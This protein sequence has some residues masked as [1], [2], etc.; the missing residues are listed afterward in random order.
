MPSLTVWQHIYANV[1]REQSPEHTAGFQTLYYSHEGLTREDIDTIESRVFYLFDAER[2]SKKAFFQTSSGK[3]VLSQITANADR[4]RAGRSGLYLAHSFILERSAF[5][6]AGLTPMDL[7]RQLPFAKTVDDA[8]K[9]GVSQAGDIKPS[10][11]DLSKP[12]QH[13][14]LKWSIDGRRLFARFVTQTARLQN[15]RSAVALVGIPAAI[16]RAL[17]DAFHLLPAHQMPEASFDT[18]FEKGGNLSFTYCWAVGFKQ[19]PRQP[20][21]RMVDVDRCEIEN[22]FSPEELT[23]AYGRWIEAQLQNNPEADLLNVKDAADRVCRYLDGEDITINEL[24]DT[25]H[26]ILDSVL[27]ANITYAQQ[28]LRAHLKHAMGPLLGNLVFPT[29]WKRLGGIEKLLAIRN[30]VAQAELIQD[31]SSLSHSLDV[32]SFL[33]AVQWLV[34]SANF[35]Q[36]ATFAPG[37]KQLNKSDLKKIAT[38]TEPHTSIPSLF[39]ETLQQVQEEQSGNSKKFFKRFLGR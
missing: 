24:Q 13:K 16:E 12:A 23:T 28:Q 19:R 30:G 2:P 38:L 34:A 35:E 7:F 31:L 18:W 6:Q 26:A 20:I 8:A 17:A 39:R 9:C 14:T 33:A 25:P 22:P 29:T 3:V 1:E 36:L 32:K 15:D 37:L 11:L 21:Y 27:A 4:D 5:I 10:I